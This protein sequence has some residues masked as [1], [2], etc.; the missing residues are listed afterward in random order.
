MA[1]IQ[2]HNEKDFPVVSDPKTFDEHSGGMLERFVFNN[3]AVLML[4]FLALT[5]FLG[6]HALNLKVNASFDRM[7]PTSHPYI[8]NFLENRDELKGLGNTIRVVVE[9]KEGDIF[10]PEYLETLREVNDTVSMLRGV[11]RPWVKSIWSPIVRWSQVSEIGYDSGPVMPDRF[12]GSPRAIDALRANISRSGVVGQLVASNFQSSAI[13]V[14]LLDLYAD[15]KE[16][17]DYLQLS[18]DLEE[19]VRALENDKVSIHII[20]FAKVAGDLIEGLWQVMSYFAISVL[21]AASFV[22]SFTRCMRSTLLLVSVSLLGVV[23]LLGVMELLGFELDPYSILVPFLVFAI[24]LSHGAQKMNGIMQDIGRGTHR[25]V[26]ARYTFRRL[27]L[28]GLTAL[29]ANVVGFA[30]LMII[31]IPVIRDLAFATSIGVSILIFTKLI[32]IPVSL[33]YIGVSPSAA[34]RSIQLENEPFGR[35]LMA[36]FWA[37]CASFAYRGRATAAVAIGLTIGVVAFIISFQVK[38]GDL[39]AGAPELR[40]DSRYNQDN[41]YINANYGMSSDQFAVIVRTEEGHCDTYEAL[42]ETGRLAWSLEHVPG[43][44]GTSSFYDQVVRGLQGTNEG[45]PKW[46]SLYNQPN[47]VGTA[48]QR[49]TSDSP[50]TFNTKCSVAPLI[51]SLT[52]HKAD[53]LSRVLHEVET[54]AAEHNQPGLEFLPA[55]GTAGIEAVT[56]I[57]VRQANVKMLVV[58]YLVTAILCLITFRS[59]R[60]VVVAMVPLL[61]TSFLCES[62]MVWLGIGIKVSTLP[63][64]ALGVGVGVDYALYL[65]NVQLGHQ[66]AGR[67]LAQSYRNALMFTGKIVGLIG[68][69][70]AAGVATWAWS[71]IKFQADMG[72]LLTFMFLWNMLGAL[73][74][75]PALSYFLLSDKYFK[76]QIAA[77]I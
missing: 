27:F 52:D 24:G 35:G 21:I 12:D 48:V 2:Q 4:A 1:G 13:V 39:D 30:V 43:V 64:I 18:R 31:D 28:A 11:D 57:V 6:T 67:S 8:Q 20:G 9:A 15:T 38:I 62:I 47:S 68:V 29:V 45:N 42:L 22:F 37:F 53:T 51:A 23:W 7:I 46:A 44:Q 40:P 10:D 66:R 32:L 75:I 25:Y 26:A 69:T 56:N 41:A 65:L 34:Q 3:R 61:I 17:L 74:L 58:L 33:S 54:F 14:P 73:I 77:R 72:I 76:K 70:M 16:N 55:A 63:V 49:I 36:N 59:W 50:G 5:L 60:A 19:K 71:P